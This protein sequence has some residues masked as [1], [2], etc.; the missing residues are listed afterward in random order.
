MPHTDRLLELAALLEKKQANP[1]EVFPEITKFDL[2]V[3]RYPVYREKS[4]GVLEQCGMSACAIGLACLHPPF[5]KLGLGFANAGHPV[6]T[7]MMSNPMYTPTK[8][9]GDP[10]FDPD[11]TFNW[12]AVGRFFDIDEH[13]AEWLFSVC[14]YNKTESITTPGEVAQRIREFLTADPKG[15]SP[16]EEYFDIR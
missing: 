14:F 1:E 16:R 15:I 9:V 7:P 12:E 2:S 3:W 6:Y 8:V 10:V 5:R 11:A 13:S 4:C